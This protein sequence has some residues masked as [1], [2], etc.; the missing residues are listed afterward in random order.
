MGVTMEEKQEKLADKLRNGREE[1]NK[2]TYWFASLDG[3]QPADDHFMF[4]L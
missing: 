2:D 4:G 1:A 3:V